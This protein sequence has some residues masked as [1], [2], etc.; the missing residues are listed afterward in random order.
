VCVCECV[1]VRVRVCVFACVVS[2]GSKY[3]HLIFQSKSS[4]CRVMSTASVLFGFGMN[5]DCTVV[6]DNN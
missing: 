3:L 1:C 2:P 5:V 6:L 4:D